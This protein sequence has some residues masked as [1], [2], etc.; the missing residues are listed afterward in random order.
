VRQRAA[1][2]LARAFVLLHELAAGVEDQVDVLQPLQQVDRQRR[3][4][5][6][7]DD[8]RAARHQREQDQRVVHRHRPVQR[9]E[10][11]E[12]V[13]PGRDAQPHRAHPVDLAP[14][15]RERVD[16]IDHR[17]PPPQPAAL[18]RLHQLGLQQPVADVL[19]GDEVDEGARGRHAALGLRLKALYT[20]ASSFHSPSSLP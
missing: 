3:V 19:V 20:W 18:E 17:H 7:R 2:Q 16:E 4:V 15:A 11:P 12:L 14:A 6:A 9:A 5:A 10:E 1:A 13:E 8:T